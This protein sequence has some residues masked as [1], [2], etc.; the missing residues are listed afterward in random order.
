MV[1]AEVEVLAKGINYAAV[2]TIMPDGR[3]QTQIMWVDCDSDHI[4]L[5]TEVHRQKFKNIQRDPR[6]TVMLWES[7][8]PYRYVEVRG[9]VVET[10]I[11][12]EALEHI[13]RLAQKYAGRPFGRE[14]I[15]SERVVLGVLPER[16]VK[17]PPP[18]TPEA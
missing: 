7:A 1:D 16:V 15:R 3:P 11:G 13:D 4:L 12:D 2:T 18:G 8:N 5:N 14:S 10:I 17:Y 9:R 6:V